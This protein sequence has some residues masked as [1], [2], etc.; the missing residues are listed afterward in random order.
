MVESYPPLYR[1]SATGHELPRLLRSPLGAQA[2]AIRG[3]ALSLRAHRGTTIVGEMGTGKSFIA[4][5]AAHAAGFQRVLVLCPPHLT[6]KW[7]REVEATVPGAQAAIVASITDLESLRRWSGA[8]PRFAVMSRERAKLSYRWQPAVVERWAAANGRL[9]RD[10]TTGEPFR[11]PCCPACAGQ[12]VD[13]GR[14]AADGPGAG[15]PQAS[16][17]ALRRA[18]LAGRTPPAPGATRSPTTSST[19]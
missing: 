7:K 15:P 5:A 1:P 8:G 18:P 11:V 10:E 16:L 6:R 9:V 3:A 4:A 19:G 14:R 17:P 12:I 2:D 13:T